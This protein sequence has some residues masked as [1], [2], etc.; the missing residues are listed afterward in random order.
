MGGTTQSLGPSRPTDTV[1]EN[2]GPPYRS[3]RDRGTAYRP[4]VSVSRDWTAADQSYRQQI[5]MMRQ[6]VEMNQRRW[7]AQVRQQQADIG[8][9]TMNMQKALADRGDW[10]MG[11]FFTLGY[12]EIPPARPRTVGESRQ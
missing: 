12:F 4:S 7:E 1:A 6:Q 2:A 11:T 10:P 3:T 9:I 5:D 8:G